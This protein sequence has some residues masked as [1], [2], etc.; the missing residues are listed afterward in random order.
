MHTGRGTVTNGLVSIEVATVFACA[1]CMCNTL[2]GE[3]SEQLSGAAIFLAQMI[4]SLFG[5]ALRHRAWDQLLLHMCWLLAIAF[6]FKL[7]PQLLCCCK[8]SSWFQRCCQ[9][10]SQAVFV[11]FFL[12]AAC[13]FQQNLDSLSDVSTLGGI[14]GLLVTQVLHSDL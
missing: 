1:D 9:L 2:R 5:V 8:V 10:C 3:L 11:L 6:G 13:A 14:T 7:F 4:N 12:L